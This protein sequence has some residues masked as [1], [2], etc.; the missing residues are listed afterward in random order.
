MKRSLKPYRWTLRTAILS[1]RMLASES[2]VVR[3]GGNDAAEHRHVPKHLEWTLPQA[4]GKRNGW[5]ARQAIELG[6]IAECEHGD[7]VRASHTRR[8]VDGRLSEPV[9]LQL[10]D[11]R[12]RDLEHR[13]LGAELQAAG[14]ARLHAC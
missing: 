5:I 1:V 9:R 4:D 11:S 6:P 14:G 2:N 7:D 12:V 8:I 3:R 10:A 13:F